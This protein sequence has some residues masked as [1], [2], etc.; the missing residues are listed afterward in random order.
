MLGLDI[1]HY[2]DKR[3]KLTSKPVAVQLPHEVIGL[4]WEDNKELLKEVVLGNDVGHSRGRDFWHRTQDT[5]WFAHLDE[6]WR[7]MIF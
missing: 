5:P 3:T 4:L 2:H 1:E 7:Q 6:A